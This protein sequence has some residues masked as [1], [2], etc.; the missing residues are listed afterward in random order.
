MVNNQLLNPKSI[1]IIGASNDTKKPG[2]NMLKN[3]LAGGFAGNLYAVNPKEERVQGIKSFSEVKEIPETDLAILAIP[4]KYCPETVK[5]LAEEKNTKAFIIISAGFGE[6]GE[7][8][9]QWEQQIVLTVNS[10]DGCLIGPNCIGVITENYKGVFTAPVP[11]FNPKGCDLIS[12]SGATAVFIMEA[13]MALGVSFVNVFSVGNAAQTGVEDILEYMDENFDAEKDPL[14]KL[15]YLETISNPQKLLKHASSLIK[16]G[17][18]IAAIKAGSTTE[19]SRAATSHTGAIA[20]SDMTVRALFHKAGIVYCSSREELLSVASIFN[21]KKLEGKNIAIITHA[22]GS[23]VML[24]DELSKG[25]LKVPEIS[26]PDAE[27]LKTFLYPGSS[28]ANPIDFLATGTAEQLGIIIDYCEHKFDNIDAMAVVFGSPGLFDVE[29]VYNVLS[30]K[31]E[32]CNKPIFPVL[33]SVVNAQREIQ[34]FL[35]KGHI[36]FPDEVVLGKALSQVFNTPEPVSE[37][38]SLPKIDIEKI[39]GVI[40][41]ASE[42]YLDAPQTQ[43]LL[44]AAGIPRVM[45]LVENS[46][47]NLLAAMD[48]LE[49]PVVM[50]VVGPLHKSDAKGV[51]LNI[52]SKEEVSETF[53]RLMQID[54]ARA[55]MVQPQLAGLELFVGV[56]KEPGFN[57]TILCGLGGIFIEVL[58]DVSA[59]LSPISKNEAQQ[60]VQSLRGYKLIQGARG[61]EGVDENQFVEIIQRLSALAEAVPEITEMDINPL[62]GTWK[63]IV[64]VDARVRLR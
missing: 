63:S 56:M 23:A 61:R 60:M 8:G 36:N 11:Q 47:E 49:F 37:A 2:G 19:G 45:E 55:V 43:K 44:D 31:L 54:S 16:K 9:K 29:N 53:D 33:P 25:G 40:D 24:A 1:A 14:I 39:R 42:G 48:S 12:G 30:V 7:Q 13:G 15:L 27:K 18:K 59:G 46:K 4:A 50:K 17:A 41:T 62:I 20:S 38:I 51:V 3:I 21:Y 35:K 34:S 6:A 22:G 10:V 28:V 32:I 58:N 26:G 57:H 52:T 5:I 64:A